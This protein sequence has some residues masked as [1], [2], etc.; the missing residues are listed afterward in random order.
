VD[1]N[2]ASPT[3]TVNRGY[4]VTQINKYTDATDQDLLNALV[5]REAR[6]R[7]ATVEEFAFK[8]AV[9]PLHGHENVLLIKREDFNLFGIYKETAWNLSLASGEADMKHVARKEG[10]GVL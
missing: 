1:D 10:V 3:S 2:P 7:L 9:V 6:K 4:A 8:T 5:L